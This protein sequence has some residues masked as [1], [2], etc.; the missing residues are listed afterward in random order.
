MDK[1]KEICKKVQQYDIIMFFDN[2]II[3]ISWCSLKV[4][5]NEKLNL[6]WHSQITRVQYMEMTYSESQTPLF[7]PSY[8]NLICLKDLRRTGKSQH[9]TDCY[10]TVGV[11]APNICICQPMFPTL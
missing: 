11:Y 10:V 9:N 5:S 6:S 7:P 1:Y 4:P 2:G 3:M 8:I